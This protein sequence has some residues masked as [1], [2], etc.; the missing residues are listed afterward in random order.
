MSEV[1]R[2]ATMLFHPTGIM[3]FDYSQQNF[4][5][6]ALRNFTAPLRSKFTVKELQVD[7]FMR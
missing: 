5:I 1:K 3:L 7:Y 6:Q 2:H 4:E